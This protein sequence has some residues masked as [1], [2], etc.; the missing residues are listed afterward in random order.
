MPAAAFN[1]E[2]RPQTW[3][4]WLFCIPAP[5]KQHCDVKFAAAFNTDLLR[6][7]HCA[8]ADNPDPLQEV[9]D[10]KYA[11]KVRHEHPYV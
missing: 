8:G 4:E 5:R 10:R 3:Y 2:A 1:T 9:A 6:G 11:E 7:S